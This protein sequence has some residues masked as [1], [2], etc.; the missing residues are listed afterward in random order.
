MTAQS[1]IRTFVAIE[2]P[3]DVKQALTSAQEE[4]R[5]HMGRAANAI[6]WVRPESIH[7][8]LQFLGD[9]A[10]SSIPD[11]VKA[12]RAASHESKPMSLELSGLGVFPNLRRPRVLWA[13]LDG[14]Q[15]AL[16][17]LQRLHRTISE[18]LTPL[19]FKPDKSFDPHLTLGRVRDTVRPGE[20]AAISDVVSSQSNRLLPRLPFQAGAI[21]LMKSDLQPGGSVYTRLAHLELA[22]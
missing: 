10:E 21:S 6:R 19:G 1:T 11:I 15:Q 20:L 16:N 18:E 9:V 17:D 14:T 13:G 12:L 7:L 4:L 8:T 3:E 2:L 22:R 5:A